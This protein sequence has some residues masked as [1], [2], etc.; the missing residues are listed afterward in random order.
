MTSD[1]IRAHLRATTHTLTPEGRRAIEAFLD[2]TDL[3]KFADLAPT[4]SAAD[5]TLR[6]ARGIVALTRAAELSVASGAPVGTR[7]SGGAA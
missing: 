6:A 2:E 5:T 4:E 3:V 7:P 1:E